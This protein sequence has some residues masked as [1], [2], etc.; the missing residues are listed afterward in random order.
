MNGEQ[1]V[2]ARRRRAREEKPGK[3]LIRA[4]ADLAQLDLLYRIGLL[5]LRPINR[6]IVG[7]RMQICL[8]MGS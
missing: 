2:P 1:Q 7:V 4:A 6:T 5:D 3:D 8:L